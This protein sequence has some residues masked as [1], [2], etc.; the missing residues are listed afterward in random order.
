MGLTSRLLVAFAALIFSLSIYAAPGD[1]GETEK[2]GKPK[3][4][5]C[6]G[7]GKAACRFCKGS[8]KMTLGCSK[9]HGAREVKNKRCSKYKGS[10]E[11]EER[12]P[13]CKGKGGLPCITCAGT[14][15]D[16][17]GP[18]ETACPVCAG[19]KKWPCY[20]CAGS[21]KRLTLCPNDLGT[22]TGEMA[23]PYCR[24]TWGYLLCKQCKGTGFA[25]GASHAEA[26]RCTHCDHGLIK[27]PSCGGNRAV[28]C[29][30]CNKKGRVAS[31][32]VYCDGKG[33]LPCVSCNATGLNWKTR[34]KDTCPACFGSI[35]M[36]CCR[37]S[38]SGNIW[39]TCRTCEGAACLKCKTSKDGGTPA[40]KDCGGS[41]KRK[42]GSWEIGCSTCLGK[43]SQICPDCYD[44]GVKPCPDCYAGI[45][46]ID[47]PCCGGK[48]QS[49]CFY[50]DGAGNDVRA[51]EFDGVLARLKPQ[52]MYKLVPLYNFRPRAYI[53]SK[54]A[55]L[56]EKSADFAANDIQGHYFL[57]LLKVDTSSISSS[58]SRLTAKVTLANG[59]KGEYLFN[60]K[61]SKNIRNL[62]P[63]TPVWAAGKIEKISL[64]Q[65]WDDLLRIDEFVVVLELDFLKK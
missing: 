27:C 5:A 20:R 25:K 41:G 19:E 63:D 56:G 49:K 55:S 10:G 57:Y 39:R 4:S 32:C 37:C 36:K 9:C 12:C 65:G 17:S 7:E 52:V 61:K 44:Y 33:S 11:R 15:F 38:G 51:D 28:A 59:E 1:S 13:F 60:P 29:T 24:E 50:C 45:E 42:H 40:C 48:K 8:K 46:R 3:C 18:D 64:I 53:L 62:D 16:C 43:G 31:A 2:V 23:C 47:C 6:S 30:K 54:I 22:A 35:T 26:Q 34:E 21:G 14:G 58:G